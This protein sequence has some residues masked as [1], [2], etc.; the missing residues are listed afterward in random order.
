MA[1]PFEFNYEVND[2]IKMQPFNVQINDLIF[3]L[4][5]TLNRK[6]YKNIEIT[7]VDRKTLK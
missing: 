2:K 1:I 4:N 7:E 5:D 3:H 6:F